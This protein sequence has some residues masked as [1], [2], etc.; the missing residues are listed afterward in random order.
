MDY[1][2]TTARLGFR[3]WREDDLPLATSLWGDSEVSILLGG[4]FTPEQIHSRLTREIAQMQETGLQLW[5]IFLREGGDFAGCAGLR[6]YQ[7]SP[8]HPFRAERAKNG[9][10]SNEPLVHELGYHL[11]R[12]SWGKGLATEAARAVIDHAFA[13]LNADALFAGH[14]PDNQASRHV[15]LKLGFEYTGEAIYPPLG[16]L[17]PTYLLRRP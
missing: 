9:A 7:L 14:H 13:S 10:P 3:H 15:L 6:P 16:W 2:L 11:V 1:F 17:E 8:S 5:P 4:P 12:A